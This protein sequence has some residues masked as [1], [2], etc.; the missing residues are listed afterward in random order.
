MPRRTVVFTLLAALLGTLGVALSARPASAAPA[1]P[2]TAEDQYFAL[3]NQTRAARG[4][5]ALTRDGGL[6]NLARQWSSNM[7]STGSFNHRPNLGAAVGTVEPNWRGAA[8]NIGMGD[9][10]ASNV[11]RIHDRFVASPGH[12]A[13]IIGDFNRVGVGVIIVGATQYVTVNFLLGPSISPPVPADPQPAPRTMAAAG[14]TAINPV[15]VVDTR[16]W[17]SAVGAGGTF[18]FKPSDAVGDASGAQAVAVNITVVG[19][20]GPGFVTVW[21][22]DSARPNVSSLNHGAG[23]TKANST[24]VAV[25]GDGKVCVYSQSGGQFLVDLSGYYKANAGLRYTPQRPS[26]LLDTRPKGGQVRS[27]RFTV[28]GG[29]GAAAINVTVTA[30]QGGG[31]ITVWPCDQAQPTASNLNFENG[32]TAANLVL[33]RVAGNGEVCLFSSTPAH[34]IADVQGTAQGGGSMLTAA[35]PRRG[36][37]TRSGLGGHYGFVAGDVNKPLVVNLKQLGRVAG[38][39]TG[40][41]LTITVTGGVGDGWMSVYPCDEGMPPTSNVNFSAGQTV[42]NAVVSKLDGQGK[43]CIASSTS[44]HVLADVVGWLA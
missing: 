23:E 32:E 14:L 41:V 4:L 1:S 2:G 15:R 3:I 29:A 9:S 6:D 43:V 22:C 18:S 21:P 44:A 40:A 31:Y 30:P 36:I 13:N 17:P 19:A 12:F 7:G 33:T 39:A 25:G 20:F 34:L 37:D 26:R 28:P 42:A 11:A 16:K 10:D 35:D 24:T 5:G 27:A 38:N 8:E